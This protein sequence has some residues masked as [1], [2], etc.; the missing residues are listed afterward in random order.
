MRDLGIIEVPAIGKWK[1]LIGAPHIVPYRH[2]RPNRR[3]TDYQI[4]F[5]SY[6]GTPIQDAFDATGLLPL[7]ENL[8]TRL[9]EAVFEIGKEVGK[10]LLTLP[11]RL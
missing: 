8:R 2:Y 4:E 6:H 5:H 10:A 9:N 1:L 3:G 7:P 11:F